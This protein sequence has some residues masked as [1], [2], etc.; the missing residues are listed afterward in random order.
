[1]DLR[2]LSIGS[3]QVLQTRLFAALLQWYGKV[4]HVQLLQRVLGLI[5]LCSAPGRG[6]LPYLAGIYNRHNP[7][8]PNPPSRDPPTGVRQG[9]RTP[10]PP[11]FG[12]RNS[13]KEELE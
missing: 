8:R 13:K 11:I 7:T 5:G 6:Y 4:V 2:D 1:M 3:S 12:S 9:S 10:P